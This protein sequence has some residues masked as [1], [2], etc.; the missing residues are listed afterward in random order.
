MSDSPNELPPIRVGQANPWAGLPAQDAA[1][2]GRPLTYGER[3]VL[4]AFLRFRDKVPPQSWLMLRGVVHGS[5]MLV[6]F[7][8][9]TGLLAAGFFHFFP[10]ASEGTNYDQE[11]DAGSWEGPVALAIWLGLTYGFLVR[12]QIDLRQTASA[13]HIVQRVIQFDTAERLLQSGTMSPEAND[14]SAAEVQR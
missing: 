11:R 8:I 5:I 14:P 6:L 7:G 9:L 12:D 10:F 4:R 3:D 1:P 2:P 13:W